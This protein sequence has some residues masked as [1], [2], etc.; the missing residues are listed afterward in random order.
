M[1]LKTK[2]IST[3]AIGILGVSMF[4]A[5]GEVQ[6]KHYNK[7]PNDIPAVFK[8]CR[9]VISKDSSYKKRDYGTGEVDICYTRS[10]F[11]DK[12]LKLYTDMDYFLTLKDGDMYDDW[13]TSDYGYYMRVHYFIAEKYTS[14]VK[15]S[16]VYITNNKVGKKDTIEVTNLQKND[17]VKVYTK[18]NKV[19]YIANADSQI[20]T[21]KS[22][23][24]KLT[25]SVNDLGQKAGSV[26]VTVKRG[27]LN[28]SFTRKISFNKESDKAAIKTTLPLSSKNV[29]IKNNKNKHDTIQVKNLVK[30]QKVTI[31]DSKGKLLTSK[32]ATGK[33]VTLKVKQLGKKSGYLY[34]A[35]QVDGKKTSQK[36]KVKFN[37]EK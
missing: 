1:K 9:L 31:Y 17:V 13:T 3:L 37:A 2:I 19:T 5:S 26:Y 34:L 4:G 22:K 16:D 15:A 27:K 30:K 32:I 11:Y 24:S 8:E 20:A 6:A 12:E 36:I 18:R 25:L 33:T 14:A 21:G 29:T 28:E 7:V 10:G 35:R 23:G